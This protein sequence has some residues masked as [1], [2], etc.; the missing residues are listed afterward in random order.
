VA[1]K[2]IGLVLTAL[3]AAAA[4]GA[5][6]NAAAAQSHSETIL[7]DGGND[8]FNGIRYHSF[9]IPSL[10]RT[11]KN[12][13]IAFVEGRAA[14]NDDFGNINLL[15]RRS[16]DNGKTWQGIGQVKGDGQGVWGNPTAVVDRSNN[17]I[18]LFLNHQPPGSGEVD[19]WDDR[20]VWLTSSTDDGASWSP[21]V[22]MSD[23]LK[24]RTLANGRSWNWDAVGPGVGIQTTVDHPGRLVI[25][26]QHRTIYSDD[27]GATWK[28]DLLRTTDGKAMEQTGEATVLELANGALYRNDRP[29]T[30]VWE[31]TKRRMVATG[32]I[33]GGF[34]PFAAA[35]CLLDPKNE[36]STMRYNADAP[37]RLAFVNSASTVTRTK[38]RIR[39]SEDEGRT[40]SYSRPFSDAPLPGE[41]A[42][43]REGGYSSI[44]KTA[45]YHVGALIEVN[46]N[47]S[48]SGTSHRSIAFRKVN[49]PWIQAGIKEPG[50]TGGI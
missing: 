14:E 42:T 9:R 40:W 34:T 38:M 22:D 20:Q 36:A 11:T 16:T 1:R 2:T 31:D 43:Y 3:I 29:T 18:W 33:G 15:F 32:R 4:V 46:E 49:L 5:P 10:I 21:A 28:V 50:C 41:S 26:A 12:T 23:T 44:V 48:S 47:T 39:M 8:E 19:S 25:P 30:P 45:D 24:P 17:K 35:G 6:A 13:L 27:H 37:A 7:F